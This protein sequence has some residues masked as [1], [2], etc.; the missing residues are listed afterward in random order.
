M[1]TRNGT[2]KRTESDATTET[3]QRYERGVSYHERNNLYA[4]TDKNHRYFAGDQ[5]RGAYLGSISPVRFNFIK[6]TVLYKVSTVAQ[7]TMSL[8][9][10]PNAFSMLA[11]QENQ[12]AAQLFLQAAEKIC[13]KLNGHASRMWEKNK[14][15]TVLWDCVLEAAIAGDAFLYFYERDGEVVCEQVDTTNVYF[16]NENERD[17]QKQPYILI[18]FRQTV[19]QV[20]REAKQNGVPEDLLRQIVPDSDTATQAGDSAKTE[21][22]TDEDGGKCMVVLELSRKTHKDGRRCVVSRKSTRYVEIQPERDQGHAMYPMAHMAWEPIKGCCRGYGEVRFL[23]DNQIEENKN[24]A[25]RAVAVMQSAYPKMIYRTDAIGDPEALYKTGASIGVNDMNAQDVQN[26]VRYLSPAS[27]SPDAYT[28]TEELREVTRNLAGASEAALGD[29]NPENASGKA[30]LA[31]RDAAAAPLSR[32][33]AAYR[34]FV[35]DIGRVWFDMWAAYSPEGKAVLVTVTDAM[36]NEVQAV[37][38][39]PYEAMQRLKVHVNVDVSP[40][41]AYS[42][43]AVEQSLE[44]CL[45]NGWITFEEYVDAL[46][47]DSAAPKGKLAEILQKR[48][49]AAPPALTG[50]EDRL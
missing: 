25:R 5:W 24:L 11:G 9:Y 35:E 34:Q 37:E 39:I 7:N 22:E 41:D 17:L 38:I 32:Q 14:M 8:H 30:I 29:I 3:W 42:K 48:A 43:Y 36:G 15:D 1:F 47:A 49:M 33:I 45:A 4:Q 2:G 13:Q 44:N 12:G 28:L 23:I 10:E 31:V 26:Y 27:T 16:G 18:A 20:R 40:S 46:P 50:T 6:P 21:V 19:E